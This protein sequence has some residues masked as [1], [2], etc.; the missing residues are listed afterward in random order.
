M[1]NINIINFLQLPLTSSS[2][3]PKTLRSIPFATTPVPLFYVSVIL[4]YVTW[5]GSH[6]NLPMLTIKMLPLQS[7]RCDGVSSML[8]RKTGR[9]L[10]KVHN[11]VSITLYDYLLHL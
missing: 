6:R 10:I 3:D 7:A 1:I 5:R 4:P 8:D 9:F 11:T 2:L